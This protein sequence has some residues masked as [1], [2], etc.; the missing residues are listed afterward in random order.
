M[1]KRVQKGGSFLCTDEYMR[2]LHA[3]R[4]RQR[5]IFTLKSGAWQGPIESGLGWHLVRIEA[6]TP[7]G[8]GV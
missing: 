2:A 6:L 5:R 4:A 1:T 7:D 8:A 3:G